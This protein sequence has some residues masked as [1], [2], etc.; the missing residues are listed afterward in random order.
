MLQFKETN[1]SKLSIHFVGNP[2]QDEQL[3]CSKSGI[4]PTDEIKELLA[5]YFLKPFKEQ[6]YFAFHHD[7]D[8]NLN[9]VYHYAKSIFDNPNQVHFQSVNIAKHLFSST[10][11]PKI[12]AGELYVAY[13]TDCRVGDE[14]V[15]A[16]GIFK[17]E[18]KE[19][20]LKVYPEGTEFTV[21]KDSGINI[22]KLDKGCLI[23]NTGQDTGYKVAVVDQINS[24]SEAAQFWQADF[25][26]VAPLEDHYY[27]TEN[28]LS[29]CQGFATEAF[30]EAARL[31]Q[32][33][34]VKNSVEYFSDQS[35]F[36]IREFEEKVI[37]EPE[38]IE[39][40]QE[41]KTEF[42]L[43][44]KLDTFDEFDISKPALK[45]A[46]KFI[47]S[48]IKLDKNFHVYVHGSRTQIDRGFDEERQMNF[49]TLYFKEES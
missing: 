34:L 39:S 30:P 17:S 9:E 11:H 44:N 29:L 14:L 20:F 21:E 16:V 7:S 27:H 42:G 10:K 38:L 43:R 25:L 4:S 3:I 15:D 19:T 5:K 40:F 18:S 31:D 8:L 32:I 13:F 36:N 47:R 6:G 37:Q 22:N 35:V 45:N 1:I 12:K 49:Y 28:Y 46:K 2:A 41:Y 23:F 33:D 48:V 24:N 26:N